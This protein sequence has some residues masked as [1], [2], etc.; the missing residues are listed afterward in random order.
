MTR[1]VRMYD[2]VLGD[3]LARAIA[4]YHDVLTAAEAA[5]DRAQPL[6]LQA[7]PEDRRREA[8][9]VA[10]LGESLQKA[11]AELLRLAGRL[12]SLA[13][14]SSNTVPPPEVSR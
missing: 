7:C 13:S 6:A 8:A 4:D 12:E 14:V 5:V 2:S 10:A 11:G 3:M 1:T 9:D